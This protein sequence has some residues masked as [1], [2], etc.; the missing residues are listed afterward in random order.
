[1]IVTQGFTKF[2]QIGRVVRI[3][4][5]HDEGKLA[6]I[7]DIVND[8]RALIDGPTSGV[9]RQVIPIRRLTLTQFHIKEVLRG[10]RSVLLKY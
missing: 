5:G 1:M 4:Y 3:N 8:K 2:V 10:Q 7:V 6:T 9:A